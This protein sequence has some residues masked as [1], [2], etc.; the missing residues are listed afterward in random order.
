MPETAHTSSLS[1]RITRLVVLLALASAALAATAV[2]YL[3][4]QRMRSAAGEQ[5]LALLKTVVASIDL[6]LEARRS[7]LRVVAERVAAD[8]AR[9]QDRADL[10]KDYHSLRSEF[11]SVLLFDGG[12]RVLSSL[13][14]PDAVGQ[15]AT[16][17][18]SQLRE[19]FSSGTGAASRVQLNGSVRMP[20]LLILE[21]VRGAG[22]AVR[23]ALAGSVDPQGARIGGQLDA[24]AP[25]QRGYFFIID[26]AGTILHH[27]D[28]RRI[29]T[30]ASD[31]WLRGALTG[32]EGRREGVDERGEPALLAYKRLR[33][34]PWIVGAVHPLDD[35]LAGAVEA[36]TSAWFA[37]MLVAIGSGIAGLAMALR[38]LRPFDE[39]HQQVSDIER[40]TADVDE[41]DTRRQDEI[42]TLGRALHAVARKCAAAEDK[43]ARLAFTDALTGIAN[44]R[45]LEEALSHALARSRRAGRMVAVAYL[46]IDHFKSINDTM[47]HQAG[48]AVLVEFA[49][50]LT[51]AVRAHDTVAR[52]AGDEFMVVFD[53]VAGVAEAEEAARRILD[54][55]RGSFAYGSRKLHVTTSIGVALQLPDAAQGAMELIGRADAALYRAKRNGRNRYMI[56][57]AEEI[58]PAIPHAASSRKVAMSST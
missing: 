6:Q 22:G 13:A 48:D 4:D 55:V 11:S 42:G 15:R 17:M 34:L 39:L 14:H 3:L 37:A 43:L 21:P 16:G 25:G 9:S 2:L 8:G 1:F 46:D 28:K 58:A 29:L 10:L 7:L 47:G 5:Q 30:Q 36:R 26:L 51:T 38:I 52:L 53:G 19:L 32:F 35:A 56:D 45:M 50:R 20:A 33:D 24:L 18:D 49:A 41:L 23:Y 57:A 44:R 27:P 40:G 12:G 54:C 31:A